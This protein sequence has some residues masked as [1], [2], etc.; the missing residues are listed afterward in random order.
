[1]PNSR[2]NSKQESVSML[3]CMATRQLSPVITLAWQFLTNNCSPDILVD[4]VASHHCLNQKRHNCCKMICRVRGR[5]NMLAHAKIKIR[6]FI[7]KASQSF[8]RKFAP[9]KISRYTVLCI[10]AIP[11]YIESLPTLM[12]ANTQHDSDLLILMACGI[13]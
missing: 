12:Y 9:L 7:L 6:K 5:G 8:M 3:Y 1:M 2:P 11:T 13:C 10:H 4:M